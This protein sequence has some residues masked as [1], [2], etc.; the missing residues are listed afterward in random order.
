MTARD[1]TEDELDDAYDRLLAMTT[2]P[3]Q[4]RIAR[5]QAEGY[6]NFLTSITGLL[7]VVFVLKGQENLSKMTTGPR[8]W[9][10]GLLASGFLLL[11]VASWMTVSAVHEKPGRM[12]VSDAK[13]LLVYERTRAETVRRMT[14]LARW[15]GLFGVVAVSVASLVTWI[16]PGES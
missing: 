14:G 8:W 11:L 1:F 5:Q 6:R 15:M 3:E 10:I 16:F 7:T 2:P 13:L 4:L 12:Q 9:V